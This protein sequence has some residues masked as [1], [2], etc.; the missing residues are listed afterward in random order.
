M[1]KLPLYSEQKLLLAFEYGVI[2]SETAKAQGVEMTPEIMK[3]A[4]EMLVNEFKNKTPT[5]LSVEML[6]NILAMFETQ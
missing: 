1:L 2:L 4:E 3:K 6:T 5:R